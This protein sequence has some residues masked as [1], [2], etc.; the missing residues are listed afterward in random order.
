MPYRTY[1]CEICSGMKQIS[2]INEHNGVKEPN[3]NC[4]CCDGKG[5]LHV[6]YHLHKFN[7]NLWKRLTKGE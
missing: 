7:E 2:I 4:P 1:P 3:I 6:E 5:I